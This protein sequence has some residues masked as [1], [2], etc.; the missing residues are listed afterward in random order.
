MRTSVS[1]PIKWISTHIVLVIIVLVSLY[2]LIW[3]FQFSL[4]L[5]VEAF[6]TP[7]QWFFVPNFVNYQS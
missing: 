4:K 5:H 1:R 3:L 2:P 6:R 7:I